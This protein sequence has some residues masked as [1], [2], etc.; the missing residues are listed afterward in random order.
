MAPQEPPTPPGQP[1][2]T[3]STGRGENRPE[4]P[5]T[6]YGRA[7]DSRRDPLPAGH[8]A[9]E[10]A[11]SSPIA[12]AAASAEENLGLFFSNN[13]LENQSRTPAIPPLN[14]GFPISIEDTDGNPQT[15]MESGVI[16]SDD[17]DLLEGKTSVLLEY[18]EPCLPDLFHTNYEPSEEGGRVRF[19]P[20]TTSTTTAARVTFSAPEGPHSYEECEAEYGRDRKLTAEATAWFAAYALEMRGI[21]EARVKRLVALLNK[22]FDLP[23]VED[24]VLGVRPASARDLLTPGFG[25]IIALQAAR[26]LGDDLG[27][28]LEDLKNDY[29]RAVRQFTGFLCNNG[30]VLESG[31]DLQKVWG[32]LAPPLGDRDIPKRKTKSEVYL[33]RIEGM[34]DIYEAIND[35]ARLQRK[36]VTAWRTASIINHCFG[37]GTR[38]VETRILALEDQL[39]DRRFGVDALTNPLNQ[40]GSKGGPDRRTYV[41]EF[42]WA[43]DQFWLKDWRPLISGDDLDGPFYPSTQGGGQLSSGSFSDTT[44]RLLDYLKERRLIHPTFTVHSARKT[45]ATHYLEKNGVDVDGLLDQLGWKTTE[46]LPVYVRPSQDSVAAHKHGWAATQG[47][48]R[49][50]R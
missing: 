40:P 48:R 29:L 6:P 41:D 9:A 15:G 31:V 2:R 12:E 5:R 38:G 42:A 25:R 50:G 17:R 14:L 33:P 34:P 47:K 37:T 44:R 24:S 35:W 49:K 1:P 20:P 46:Q 21:G 23:F 4:R 11:P 19:E 13:M 36:Q 43:M 30:A 10:S 27:E 45:Y 16:A 3:S 7:V 18:V 39:F 8:P 28:E 22:F 32:V 26:A